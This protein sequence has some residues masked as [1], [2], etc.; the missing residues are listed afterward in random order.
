MVPTALRSFEY[1]LYQYKHVWR[2]TIVTSLIVPPLYLSVLG[3]G[4][5]VLVD[6]SGATAPLGG[7]AYLAFVAPGL[8]A[9]TALQ[10]AAT[11][12]THPVMAALRWHKAYVAMVRTPLGPTDVLIGHL[13]F[14][15]MRIAI[16]CTAFLGYLAAFG[17]LRSVRDLWALPAAVLVG[18]ACAV[19]M[20]AFSAWAERDASLTV[21]LRFVVTPMF[22]F[23][24]TFYPLDGIPAVLRAVFQILPLWHGVELCRS[25]I[26]DRPPSGST[27][28]HL[29]VLMVWLVGAF[30]VGRHIFGKRLAQ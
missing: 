6:K 5:G 23:S 4:L 11:E 3:L 30:L 24:G 14:I 28:L 13:A 16:V 27:A 29:A 9:A 17:V 21:L 1:W 2:G 25:I 19:P 8:L 26:L 12:S 18:M 7:A 20:T 10:I 22:L 15:L